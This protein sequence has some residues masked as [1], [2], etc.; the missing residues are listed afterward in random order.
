[1]DLESI[2]HLFINCPY[3]IKVSSDMEILIGQKDVWTG[4]TLLNCFEN[5]YQNRSL[6][7]YRTLPFLV[8]WGIWLTRNTPIFQNK[9][10][11]S[12]QCT[13]QI[14]SIFVHLKRFPKVNIQRSI[15]PLLIDKS[16]PW[17]FFDGASQVNSSLYGVGGI[18]FFKPN[19]YIS[20]SARL[21][22][23]TNNFVKIM[24]LKLLL[25]LAKDRRMDQIQVFG[26][27][28]VIIN[29]INGIYHVKSLLLMPIKDMIDRL[30]HTFI[31]I[32]ITHV[33]REYNLELDI[34]S[35]AGLLLAMDRWELKEYLESSNLLTF[36]C[37]IRPLPLYQCHILS[38]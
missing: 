20:F 28:K 19:H 31:H 38:F 7:S 18:I 33:Y 9:L 23:G 34:L 15:T 12:I 24:A 13:Y 17:G 27:S 16:H 1:M 4:N 25:T 36:Y 5:Q 26:D 11:P 37:S 29:W 30:G 21:G 10:I 8:F 3:T 32:S 22:N 2:D 6:H 14:H 35:K